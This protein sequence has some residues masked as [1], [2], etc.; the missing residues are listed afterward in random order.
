MVTQPD[1]KACLAARISEE[2]TSRGLSQRRLAEA[3]GIDPSSMNRVEKGQ[4][5]VSVGELV[6][7]ADV[8]DV[9]V[10]DL[11]AEAQS[12]PSIWLRAGSDAPAGVAQSLDLFRGVIRDYFGAQAAVE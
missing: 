6:R 10:D 11:L 2:R 12:A 7:L 9:R 1:A 5:A 3:I 8:L 4:R